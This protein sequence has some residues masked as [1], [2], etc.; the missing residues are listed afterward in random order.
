MLKKMTVL[1]AAMLLS[2]GLFVAGCEDKDAADTTATDATTD[3][4][5]STATDAAADATAEES[6]DA[7]A[8]AVDEAAEAVEEAPAADAPAAE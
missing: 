6:M 3:A 5:D 7:A 8:E 1:S 2:A 4:M